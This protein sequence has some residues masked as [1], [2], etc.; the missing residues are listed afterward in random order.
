MVTRPDLWSL[1]ITELEEVAVHISI[2]R[3]LFAQSSYKV[4]LIS[5]TSCIGE[6][7][8]FLLCVFC[9]GFGHNSLS[10]RERD[11]KGPVRPEVLGAPHVHCTELGKEFV[12]GLVK[13]VTA[14]P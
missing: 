4:A 3:S 2:V 7:D 9:L 5:D 10:G 12:R 1:L 11:W 13:F 14:V 6:V 8:W